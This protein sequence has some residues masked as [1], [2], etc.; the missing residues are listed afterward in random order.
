MWIR[1]KIE[2]IIVEPARR[3]GTCT[4]VKLKICI[5]SVLSR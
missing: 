4:T 3:A 1:D 5:S 2:L